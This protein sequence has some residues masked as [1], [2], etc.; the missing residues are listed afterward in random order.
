MNRSI[1]CWTLVVLLSFVKLLSGCGGSTGSGGPLT[2][3]EAPVGD[4]SGGQRDGG[5][6]SKIDQPPPESVWE[7]EVAGVLGLSPDDISLPPSQ[8]PCRNEGYCQ[9]YLLIACRL[10]SLTDGRSW[11][12]IACNT[13]QA[14]GIELYGWV[15]A[16]SSAV[17]PTTGNVLITGIAGSGDDSPDNPFTTDFTM[18][19]QFAPDDQSFTGMG[20]AFGIS[21]VAEGHRVG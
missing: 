5:S 14:S 11:D 9:D 7:M 21:L 8:L 10:A 17:D 16:A 15:K 20:E 3:G 13:L 1:L 2:V 6:N 18:T 12:S 4:G 19:I